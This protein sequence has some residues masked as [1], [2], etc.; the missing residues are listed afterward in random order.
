MRYSRIT[1]TT[2]L[3]V[4]FFVVSHYSQNDPNLDIDLLFAAPEVS[5]DGIS[6][7]FHGV[8]KSDRI[9]IIGVVVDSQSPR[10]LKVERSAPDLLLVRDTIKYTNSQQP[11]NL[12]FVGYDKDFQLIGSRLI[13][14]NVPSASTPGVPVSNSNRLNINRTAFSNDSKHVIRVEPRFE[15]GAVSGSA[16]GLRYLVTVSHKGQQVTEKIVGLDVEPDPKDRSRNIPKRIQ[17]IPVNLMPGKNSVKVSVI[18]QK[19][20][21]AAQLEEEFVIT[22]DAPCGNLGDK[23]AT[24]S[25]LG[26]EQVGG[27]STAGK[28]RPFLNLFI[29]VP[30]NS[31]KTGGKAPGFSVWTDFRLSSAPSQRFL[32]LKSI[33]TDFLNSDKAFGE[34]EVVQTFR[35]NAGIDIRLLKEGNII[36]FFSPG[37][38]SFSLIAGGGVSSPLSKPNQ[39]LAEIFEIPLVIDPNN[40]ENQ[41]PSPQFEKFYSRL[42]GNIEKI[43]LPDLLPSSRNIAFVNEE[44]VRF[45]RRLFVGGRLKVNFFEDRFRQRNMSPAI[46]DLTV[47]ADEA[48]TGRLRSPVMSFDG[49]TP[50]PFGNDVF[51]LYAGGSLK[52]ERNAFANV[53]SIFLRSSAFTSST[54]EAPTTLIVPGRQNPFVRSSRDTYFFGIGIDFMRLFGKPDSVAAT[55]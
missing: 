9:E 4:L 45:E 11:I 20:E 29:S 6:I 38:S 3:V 34:N 26:F 41:V 28:V 30:I 52:L 55:K 8:I 44:R 12:R 1:Q 37:K 10:L 31:R 19:G 27:S 42:R 5:N 33:T 32:N 50:L 24:R 14:Q 13:V 18:N 22:C 47:G 48:V 43:D 54:L 15:L 53:P 7:K 49:F 40:P 51:Y 46:F 2:I 39:A 21:K 25:V 16:D 35:V 17:E 23:I 36:P